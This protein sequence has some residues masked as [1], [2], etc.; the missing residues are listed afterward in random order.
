MASSSTSSIHKSIFKYDVF[1]SF[2]GEDT[3][4]TFIGHLYDALK[5]ESIET[6]KDDMDLEKGKKISKE[7]IQAIQDSR[8]HVIVFSKNYAS[9]SWCLD[10]LVKIMECQKT[11]IGHTV[12]PIF[13]DVEPTEVRK[14]SGEFGK[15]FAKYEKAEATQKW[16]EALVEATSFSGW[17][18][19]TIADG[20]E[21]EFIKKVVKEISIKLP[22]IST[23][24]YN[25]VGMRTRIDHVV[26]SLNTFRDEFCMMGIVGV[27]GSGK[28]TL[29]RAVFD[30]ICNEFEGS[31]F[32]ENVRECSLGLN[33]L[34]QQVL[35][36]V[37]KQDVIVTGLTD[38]KI[39]MKRH[40]LGR[41][42]LVVL[43]G[44]DNID[45]LE[46]LAG[47]PNWFK[48]GSKIIITTR[49]KQ[50]LVAHKVVKVIHDVNLLTHDEAICL[51]S[52]RAFGTEI[53]IP[54]Y[55]KLSAKVVS[56]AD[57]LPLTITTV[58]LNLYVWIDTLKGLEKIPFDGTL[59]KSLL[60]SIHAKED[61][62]DIFLDAACI[63]KGWK[64]DE[65]I[66]VLESYGFNDIHGLS[67]FFKG[68]S[69]VTISHD[70]NSGMHDH[71]E[72]M[73]GHPVRHL[74]PHDP[75]KHSRLWYK[76]KINDT[77]ANNREKGNFIG[78]GEKTNTF[79]FVKTQITTL[80]LNGC[81]DL[82]ELHLP[83]ECPQLKTLN[84]EGC[85]A[86]VELG[87]PDECPQLITLDLNGCEDLLELHMP[88][89]CPQ[90]ETLNLEGCRAF[91]KLDMPGECPRLITLDLN[92]CEDLLELQMPRECPQLKTL[93]LDGCMG[94]RKL[95][96]PGKCPRL[97]T[98]NL[99]GCEDL[100]ELHMPRECPQLET[101]NLEGCRAFRKLDM[102]SEFPRL[103]TLN[104]NGCEDLLEL[105][106]P[107]ICPQLETFN[108]EG[109]RGLVKLDMPGE[110]PRLIT[111]D[112][113]GCEDLLELHMP[114]ECP[115]L[116]TLNLEGCRGLVKLDMPSESPQ[117]KTLNLKG[118]RGSVKR[119]ATYSRE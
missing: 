22:S 10:E 42:V 41:K 43:D 81:E 48:R 78:K 71:I 67:V 99:N 34:Q 74:Y 87:M 53:P 54:G 92:G 33:S 51:L 16:R 64:E 116:K 28:T 25:L 21:A 72:E 109:C 17:D 91:R 8:F 114:R 60:K 62:K 113:N 68:K 19:M 37:L 20:Q 14:Q 61:L 18:L 105:H 55:E 27:G 6:Y 88:L 107:L 50:I 26:S 49:D 2:R 46:A 80:D 94:F 31:S 96:M 45:Q 90:L 32:V 7:L 13:Y 100:L 76:K 58:G 85:R 95:G 115:Q 118:C 82:L 73:G 104:L 40:M 11:M 9:S 103:I 117:L 59:Q 98:L 4:K 57:G 93:N 112:L 86:L 12:Y 56:I 108:L 24:D 119:F 106:M 83:H 35:R 102:P 39:K 101:L 77:L 38:G 52:R 97:I 44:V 5:R 89:E 29:A 47:E 36:N 63:L 23:A 69:L 111:L 84:L 75:D 110:C 66:R 15:A 79:S 65:A 70:K 30:Q 3:R 1:L